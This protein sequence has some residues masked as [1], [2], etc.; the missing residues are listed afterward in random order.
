MYL[1]ENKVIKCFLC[2]LKYV[3]LGMNQSNG[4]LDS[5]LISSLFY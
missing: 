2:R 1:S 4:A 3:T 5:F